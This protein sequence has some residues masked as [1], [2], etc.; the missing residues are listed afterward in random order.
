M[1]ELLVVVGIIALLTGIL[2]PAVST[3]R[4]IARETKQ[5]AQF[6]A[7]GLGLEAFKNDFGDYP[8]S[9]PCTW[10]ADVVPG[11]MN[12]GGAFKL[13]EALLGWDLMGVHPDTGWRVDGRNRYPYQPA[14]ATAAAA[15]GTYFLYDQAI[16]AERD[17]RKGRYI[18]IDVANPFRLGIRPPLHDGLFDLTGLA[19][20]DAAADCFLMC[21]VFGKGA[22]VTLADGTRVKAGRP[23]LYYRAN[24]ANKYVTDRLD[25]TYRGKDNEGLLTIVETNDRMHLGTPAPGMWNWNPLLNANA[26]ATAIR[27][28]RASIMTGATTTTV[29]YRPDSYLLISAGADGL[30]GTSDDIHNF[31]R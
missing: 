1:V 19:P 5:K 22:T 9:D 11:V 31:G 23:I 16:P 17:K 29:A 3:V 2:I 8:P 28:P 26:F 30:Y 4:K 7:I 25:S 20:Y 15:P 10:T 18:E 27:D 6:T 13:S 24:P 14:G 21:D 12:S